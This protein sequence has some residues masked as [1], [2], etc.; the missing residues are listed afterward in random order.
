MITNWGKVKLQI[1]A[2]FLLQIRAKFIKNWGRSYYKLRQVITSA[3]TRVD[4]RINVL[5]K[6]ARSYVCK[7]NLMFCVELVI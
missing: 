3:G 2:G 1:R 5:Q 4:N 6:L 7:K